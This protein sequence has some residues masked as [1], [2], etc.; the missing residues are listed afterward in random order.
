[1]SAFYISAA[2]KSS[3]KTSV[4]AGLAGALQRR[5]EAVQTFKKGPDYIDP[6]WLEAASGRSSYNLDFHTM[7]RDE[8]KTLFECHAGAATVSMVE[9]NKG[10]HDSVDNEGR[11][12]N[13]SMARLLNLPVLLV[14]SC[15]GM[16]RGAAPLLR[17]LVEFE[18]DLDI[19]GVILNNVGGNRHEGK[20]RAAIETYTDVTVLGAVQRSSVLEL[21]EQHLGLVPVTEAESGAHRLSA[22]AHT[23]EQ[24]VDVDTLL[25]RT[26]G[27][28]HTPSPQRSVSCSE[29][30]D[31]RIGVSKDI[32]FGFYYAGD[33]EQLARAG[34]EIVEVNTVKHAQ[35]P[36]IDGLFLGGGFPERH[37]HAIS[38]N[39]SLRQDIRSAISSGLPVYAECGGLMYLCNSLS[40]RGERH[41]MVGAL[42]ADVLMCE[43]P[44]GR[45]YVE[46]E[47][48][49]EQL[50]P[51]VASERTGRDIPAHE[52]HYSKLMNL[53]GDYRFA[54]EVHRGHGVDGRHDGLV[55]KNVLASYSHLRNTR[56]NPWTRRF[57]DFVRACKNSNAV[58]TVNTRT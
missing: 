18:P 47:E 20:L 5:G 38:A 3:G 35:L 12:S 52:F 54:Y 30:T 6:M 14:V 40:W 55:Y 15:Q 58:P 7:E 2:H 25:L 41:S 44:Q 37:M 9:G 23:I 31:V 36:Q 21:D 24:Q 57:L 46:L 48:T 51:T 43:R 45:G 53:K 39:S 27:R 8:I 50:W 32:A 19:V 28:P 13:A 1:M 29:S 11:Y 56:R 26:T 49:D 22:L 17:G 10:L 34:A 33:L 42:D 4:C 16:T